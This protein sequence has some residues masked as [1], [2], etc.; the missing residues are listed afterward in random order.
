MKLP[1]RRIGHDKIRR[2]VLALSQAHARRTGHIGRDQFA[3]TLMSGQPISL[4][5]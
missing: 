4:N 2:I 5:T 3:Q 1:G